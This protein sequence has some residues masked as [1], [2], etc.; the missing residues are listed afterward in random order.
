LNEAFLTTAN[1]G[2]I[3]TTCGISWQ[4]D[5]GPMAD[6]RNALQFSAP[7]TVSATKICRPQET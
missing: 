7:L 3:R 4:L 1:A 6:V 2:M 5:F